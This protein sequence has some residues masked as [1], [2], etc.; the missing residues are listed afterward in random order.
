M[1]SIV[2]DIHAKKNLHWPSTYLQGAKEHP[3]KEI[4]ATTSHEEN[5]TIAKQ[6]KLPPTYLSSLLSQ[7][8][9][10]SL[11]PQKLLRKVL[12][13][14]TNFQTMETKRKLFNSCILIPDGLLGS[15][16]NAKKKSHLMLIGSQQRTR[17][18]LLTKGLVLLELGT[19]KSFQKNFSKDAPRPSV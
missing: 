3:L 7:W 19:C 6:L 1:L 11:L 14:A 5:S 17:P 12:L 4:L 10:Y 2:V 9:D 13:F 8:E 18:V 16:K 15:A